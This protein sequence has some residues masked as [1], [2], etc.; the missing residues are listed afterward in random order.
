VTDNH[1]GTYTVT[2]KGTGVG[3]NTIEA[4]INNSPVTSKAPTIKVT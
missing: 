4:T 1:N 2:F 3:S